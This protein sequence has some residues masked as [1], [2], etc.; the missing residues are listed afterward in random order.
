MLPAYRGLITVGPFSPFKHKSCLIKLIL[1]T[2]DVCTQN[3][4]K[5][6]NVGF[7]HATFTFIH[8]KF[9]NMVCDAALKSFNVSF[10]VKIQAYLT[11][12]KE[13]ALYNPKVLSNPGF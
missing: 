6:K 11:I 13:S 4:E 2:Y 9:K 8:C 1:H 12:L 7:S 3:N 5:H 10:Y